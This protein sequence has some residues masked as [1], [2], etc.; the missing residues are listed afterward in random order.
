MSWEDQE[1]YASLLKYVEEATG[2]AKV[3]AGF[4][5]IHRMRAA[6]SRRSAAESH[7]LESFMSLIAQVKAA[8]PEPT[9]DAP[10]ATENGDQP[11]SKKAL[12]KIA[13]VGHL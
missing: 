13:K 8:A 6:R 2:V 10:V 1:A 7:S 3:S 5:S 12:K 9:A 4:W 11:L